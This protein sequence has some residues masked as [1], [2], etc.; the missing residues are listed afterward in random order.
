MIATEY[1]QI[2]TLLKMND[3][4]GFIEYVFNPY[5]GILVELEALQI[6]YFSTAQNGSYRT[7]ELTS[8]V[9]TL[10]K[11]LK[12]SPSKLVQG[13]EKHSKNL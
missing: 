11:S 6:S 7:D 1:S 4:T 9:K 5:P 12:I 8:D 3:S 10:L 2:Q 13:I